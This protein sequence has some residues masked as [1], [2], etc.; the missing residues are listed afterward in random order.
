[1]KRRIFKIT[2]IAFIFISVVGLNG[3]DENNNIVLFSIQN[4]IDLGKQ[5]SEEIAADP[6]TYPVM[7]KS[8]NAEAYAYLEAV[9]NA[10]LN[11]GSV[12]YKDQFVWQ[13]HIIKDDETLNA[14]ATPGGYIYVYTGLIKYLDNVDDLAGVMGHELAHADLRHTSRNLQKSYGV[15][16]LLSLL[17]GENSGDLT[18]I[19]G[20]LAGNVAGLAFS[21]DYEKEADAQSVVYLAKTDYA[22]NGAATFFEKLEASGQSGGPAFLSTH[23]SP[24]SRI[25]DINAKATE[26]GCDT[27][28]SG[29]NT[30]GMTYAE[31]QALL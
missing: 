6:T 18:K 16:F 17:I 28:L 4:D 23:P 1:M 30:A 27:T 24:T 20:Q 29:N 3:C 22:C 19:A 9:K 13:L 26:E 14:F 15:S 11:S 7:D 21:R 31:F 8:T 25:E 5:V 2:A 12:A 10:I